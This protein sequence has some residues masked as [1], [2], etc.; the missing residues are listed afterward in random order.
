MLTKIL[1]LPS[2]MVNARVRSCEAVLWAIG[3]FG[4][5]LVGILNER[6]GPLV[7]EGLVPPFEQL[8]ELFE[9]SLIQ[10]RDRLVATDRQHRAQKAREA[11]FRAVKDGSVKEVNAQVLGLRN[12]FSGVYTDDQLAAIGFT[13][14]VPQ[15]PAE[16]LELAAYLAVR[17]GDP[18]LELS[19]SR[20]G[21]FDLDASFLAREF[22]PSVERLRQALSDL[23]REE[24]L[25][26]ASQLAKDEAMASHNR[27]FLWI[28]RTVE[29]LLRLAG[30]DDLAARVRP[31]TRRPGETV[32]EFEEPD[33]D[34]EEP[35]VEGADSDATVPEDEASSEV[36]PPA[37]T[38]SAVE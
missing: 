7:E 24:R 15:Q 16:L 34:G 30:L 10:S 29:S 22:K 4:Q 6:F 19:G 8:L 36:S 33:T 1:N 2:K 28:A 18:A 25:T 12:A 17:L 21:E 3:T 23:Q 5:Q 37:E 27:D 38:A 35:E 11:T 13:R 32:E 9:A 31:S 14:R 26:E 20:F